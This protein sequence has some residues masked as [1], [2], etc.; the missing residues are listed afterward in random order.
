M[1]GIVLM[2]GT[3]IARTLFHSSSGGRTAPVEEVFGAPPVPHLR[4][5][6][7]PYDRLSPHHDWTATLTDEAAERRL[8]PV[9]A[10]DLVGVAATARTASGWAATVRVIGTLGTRDVPGTTARRLLHLRSAWFTVHE[11]STTGARENDTV[12]TIGPA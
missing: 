2:F 8:A 1:S 6:A 11:P 5:V 12:A 7:D 9:L 10:G 4:S 3:S